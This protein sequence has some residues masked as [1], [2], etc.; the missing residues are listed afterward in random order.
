M[1]VAVDLKGGK[2]GRL[3]AIS[4]NTD[5]KIR[6]WNCICDCGN[7]ACVPSYKLTSGHTSSCGC[8]KIETTKTNGQKNLVHGNGHGKG[9]PTYKTW[10]SMRC[11]CREN[12]KMRIYYFDRGITVCA[13]WNSYEVF[14]SD[15]GERPENK[16]LDRIN[17]NGN[18]EPENC[19]WAD[20]KTQQR[21]KQRTRKLVVDGFSLPIMDI[22]DT[23]GIKK[24]A[25]QYFF[26][27]AKLLKE[28]YGFVPSIE[29]S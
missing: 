4:P 11:R 1:G 15:M 26:S 12:Y 23:L 24:S 20:A 3:L 21:N 22:A 28:Y 6:R 2:F 5:K 25:M 10:A 16:T 18:Y 8:Y 13:R 17:V 14:L 19:R 7:I 29:D 27:V 9:G